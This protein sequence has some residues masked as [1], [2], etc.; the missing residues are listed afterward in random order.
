[1]L[2]RLYQY[3]ILVP[4][5]LVLGFAPFYPE[6]HIVGKFRMMGNGTLIRPLDIFDL[7][8]HAWPLAFLGFR[9]GVDLG[10]RLGGK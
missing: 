8:W 1:M 4:L 3:R 10:R 9:V 5:A 6:P 7:C 2:E